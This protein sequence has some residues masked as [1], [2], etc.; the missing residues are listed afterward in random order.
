[1]MRGLCTMCG[2]VE[3]EL[4]FLI[5]GDFAGWVCA[6]C[7][8]QLRDCMPRRFCSAGEQTEPGE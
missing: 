8:E 6:A 4:R 5:I 7:W 1:M 2:A 3:T